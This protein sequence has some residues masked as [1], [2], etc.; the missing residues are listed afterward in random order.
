MSRTV[1]IAAAQYD[2]EAVA[3]LAAYRARITRWVEQAVGQGAQLLVFPE[4]AAME[5]SAIGNRGLDLH[6]S[7]DAVSDLTDEIISIH[8]ELARKHGVMIVAGSAP[9]RKPEGTFNIAQVFGPKASM[10]ALPRSCPHH[11]SVNPGISPAGVSSRCL[12]QALPRWA[13]SSAMTSNS[14]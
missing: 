11:G 10:K 8:R 2:Y 4:Y 1:T 6:G 3:D 5:L 7:I 12:M 14:R 13:S 9:C